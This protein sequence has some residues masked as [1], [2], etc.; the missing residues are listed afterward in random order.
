VFTS[1]S[2]PQ[3]HKSFWRCWGLFSSSACHL[4]TRSSMVKEPLFALL[5][6]RQKPREARAGNFVQQQSQLRNWNSSHFARR[7]AM[8]NVP[9]NA[10]A[11]ISIFM[12]AR[13]PP[14]DIHSPQS[15]LSHP[16]YTLQNIL[17]S[18]LRHLVTWYIRF[19]RMN[20][21]R[22]AGGRGTH[23]A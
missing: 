20:H 23:Q 22:A 17:R 13:Q 9:G 11:I 6:G 8:P 18:P 5:A 4:A 3:P 2:T 19:T 16:I 21:H 10:P 1:S 14:G 15:R 12:I 7:C